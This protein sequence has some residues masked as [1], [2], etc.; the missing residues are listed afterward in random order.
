MT[1]DERIRLDSMTIS[2]NYYYAVNN[3]KVF[4]EKFPG[5]VGYENPFPLPQFNLHSK[6]RMLECGFKIINDPEDGIKIRATQITNR[7]YWQDV[8]S[9]E[10]ALEFFGFDADY[11]P[12]GYWD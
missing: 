8:K 6:G 7:G 2:N 4:L 12:I 10:E 3:A 5:C 11:K 1:K 9:Q